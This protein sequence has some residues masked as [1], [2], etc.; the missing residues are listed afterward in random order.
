MG[1]N[2]LRS[3]TW[4][5]SQPVNYHLFTSP[6]LGFCERVGWYLLMAWA[7]DRALG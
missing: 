3:S 4:K 1:H 2:E 5:R 7:A 6:L